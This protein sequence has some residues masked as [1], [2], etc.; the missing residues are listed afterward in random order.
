MLVAVD[1]ADGIVQSLS[2]MMNSSVQ[3]I[4]SLGLIGYSKNLS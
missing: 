1:D 4:S 3:D 2:L